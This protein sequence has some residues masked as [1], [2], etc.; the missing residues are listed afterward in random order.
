MIL[1]FKTT[2]HGLGRHILDPSIKKPADIIPYSYWLFVSQIINLIAVA[3]LK[4]SICAYLFAL[5]F[6]TVYNIVIWL[7]IA[8]VTVFNLILPVMANLSCTPF[9]ANWNKSL[10]GRCWYKSHQSLTYMQ[11]VSNCLTDV[12]YVVAP[13]IYLRAI[14]LPRRT[15][16]GLRI[17]FLLGWV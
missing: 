11:G 5:R 7:S 17:V 6:S 3:I 15:Q 9:E 2:H 10:K 12:V 14:Q 13:I 8:M 1:R 16:W 4:Y